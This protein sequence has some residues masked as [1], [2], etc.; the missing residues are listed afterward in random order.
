[1]AAGFEILNPQST[2]GTV[3]NA[4]A[5][6]GYEAAKSF[7]LKVTKFTIDVQ[8]PTVDGTEENGYQQRFHSGRVEGVASFQGFVIDG[9]A[10]GLQT[11][12]DESVSVSVN[13]GDSHTIGFTMAIERIRIDWERA[14]VGVPITIEGRITGTPPLSPSPIYESA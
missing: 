14:A 7:T 3:L 9:R 4:T 5:D 6:I 8:T 10:I 1:M 2:G 13:I 12:P 11:L